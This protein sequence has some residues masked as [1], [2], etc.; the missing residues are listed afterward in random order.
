MLELSGPSAALIDEPLDVRLRGLG[1]I[2]SDPDDDFGGVL[3]RARLRDDDGRVWRAT[4]DAPAHLA[5]GLAPSK[6]G[7]G[8]VPAL[9]SLRAV[10]LD[11]HAEAPDGRGAK[12]TFERRLLGDGVRVR[13]WKEREL[14][15]TAFLPTVGAAPTQPLLIDARTDATSTDLGLLAAFVAPLAAAVL[16]SRGRATVVVSELDDL[17]PVLERLGQLK[18]ARD[19]PRVL[20][21]LGAGDVVLLPPGVPMLDEG[22]AARTA[23]SDR[24][25]SI[26]G[27]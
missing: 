3:W 8:R 18:A 25:A 6:P 27:G 14:R 24:W 22:P 16:A 17:G 10:Q 4:A 19:E 23:R 2:E 15:G 11:V 20:R 9:G 7:T 26:L 21:A 12:R 5:A 1:E 13:R